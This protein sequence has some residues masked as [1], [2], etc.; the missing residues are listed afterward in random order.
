[1][2]ISRIAGDEFVIQKAPGIPAEIKLKG[3][4]FNISALVNDFPSLFNRDM[5]NK[6]FPQLKYKPA[7]RKVTY[8]IDAYGR[9]TP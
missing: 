7:H 4:Y 5:L 1:M 9:V 6:Y 3:N 8:V 2:V